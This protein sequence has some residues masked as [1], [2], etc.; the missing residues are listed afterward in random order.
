MQ[1]SAIK[2]SFLEFHKIGLKKKFLGKLFTTYK[3]VTKLRVIK[4]YL[5]KNLKHHRTVIIYFLDDKKK[6]VHN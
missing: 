6:Y 2:F 5:K 3:L 1:H 4:K